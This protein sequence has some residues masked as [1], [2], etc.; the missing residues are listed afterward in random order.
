MLCALIRCITFLL[1]R[2]TNALW[3]M[4]VILL[5]GNHWH[6]SA[7]HVA[8]FRVV[9]TRIQLQLYC[10]KI[11]PKVKVIMF[12]SN[13][14]FKEYN[15]DEYK[16]LENGKLHHN[17][18]ELDNTSRGLLKIHLHLGNLVSRPD[19]SLIDQLTFEKATWVGED[20]K[21]RQQRKF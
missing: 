2:L 13:S 18:W 5:H 4:N 12:C 1:K 9:K 3:C 15:I 7:I 20:S 14:W 16:V 11:S 10:I 19:W 21:T 6:V 17:R 8:I